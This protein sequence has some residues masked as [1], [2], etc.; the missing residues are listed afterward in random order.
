[1]KTLKQFLKENNI[2]VSNADRAKIGNVIKV[3]DRK[4]K[5]TIEDCCIV[6]NY[7]EDFLNDVKTQ[8]KIIEFL[9][10]K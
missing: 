4:F 1:M 3:N 6:N 10:T 8:K 7:D 9:S 2:S 5:K